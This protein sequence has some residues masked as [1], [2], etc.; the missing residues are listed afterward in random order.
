MS[1]LAE[2]LV[3]AHQ[4]G[5][6]VTSAS[7][8]LLSTEEGYAVQL[9]VQNLLSRGIAAWK[10]A[11]LPDGEVV[12]APILDDSIFHS[13]AKVPLGRR[14][15]LGFECELA[16]RVERR[17]PI[18]PTADFGVD[19]V[20]PVLGD[21]FAAFELLSSRTERGFQSPRPLLVADSLGTGGIVLGTS[22]GDWHGL[23]LAEI[24]NSLSVADES[25]V[26]KRGGNP[27]GNPLQAIVLLANHLARRGCMWEPNQII[28]TGAF[29]GVHHA[30]TGQ[31]VEA[32][33][34]GFPS[35]V[36]FAE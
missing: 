36:M 31:R 23:A 18:S 35:V 15:S 17:L 14:M 25:V 1:D 22:L 16:F 12:S 10:V 29:S 4:G 21:A 20:L 28:M 33:F 24:G 32:R 34:E 30:K 8:E 19:D 11:R 3:G 2:A 9:R 5:E 27:L 7:A 26:D 6:R 13:G